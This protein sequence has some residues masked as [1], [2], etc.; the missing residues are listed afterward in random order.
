MDIGGLIG[1]VEWGFVLS[2]IAVVLVF[3]AALG[4]AG[5]LIEKAADR[6]E[7]SED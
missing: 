2:V 4:A 3:S 5:L 6:A 7:A 1:S